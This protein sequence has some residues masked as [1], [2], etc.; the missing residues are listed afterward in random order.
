MQYTLLPRST[1][2]HY[3]LRSLAPRVPGLEVLDLTITYPGIP[4]RGIPQEYYTLRSIFA[5]RVPPPAIHI[6]IRR[7]NAA[8]DI[9][10]GDLSASRARKR[11]S[12]RKDSGKATAVEVDVPERE[13][14]AFESWLR[15]L[16]R[17]KDVLFERYYDIGSFARD[18][19]D[20]LVIPLRLRNLKEYFDAFCFFGP[21]VLWR[22]IVK[23]MGA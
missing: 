1:G 2:L 20:E 13:R 5:N 6:H 22:V 10:I 11:P 18:D 21:I 19:Q 3:V 7:F 8:N 15:A 17:E 9:P 4:P 23:L 16:W 12:S 14:R